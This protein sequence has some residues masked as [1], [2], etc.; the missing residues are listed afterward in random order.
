MEKALRLQKLIIKLHRN[1]IFKRTENQIYSTDI[2]W[3]H[4]EYVHSLLIQIIQSHL[5]SCFEYE[6]A[7]EKKYMFQPNAQLRRSSADVAM[8]FHPQYCYQHLDFA[9][10]LSAV[11]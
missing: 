2:Y 9:E 10:G 3:A 4:L 11:L 1:Y 7:L 5:P 8:V 6:V